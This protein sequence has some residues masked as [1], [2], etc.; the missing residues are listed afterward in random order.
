MQDRT[1]LG[2]NQYPDKRRSDAIFQKFKFGIELTGGLF[3]YSAEEFDNSHLALFGFSNN[4]F[5]LL[6]SIVF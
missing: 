1:S 4:V 3:G 5:K 2:I 6:M